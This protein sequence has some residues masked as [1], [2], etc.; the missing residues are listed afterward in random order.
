[1]QLTNNSLKVK[2]KSARHYP[3]N[4]KQTF[5][6]SRWMDF[7]IIKNLLLITDRLFPSYIK[8]KEKDKEILEVD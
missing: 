3:I 4:M 8:S 6:Q 7:T 1:M 5:K 2:I